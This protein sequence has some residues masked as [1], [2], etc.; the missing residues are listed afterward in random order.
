[1]KRRGW[2]LAP[3]V[4]AVAGGGVLLLRELRRGPRPDPG[5]L[6][7]SPARR[8]PALACAFQ[9]GD[10]L[11][12]R[13]R[14][15]S[16]VEIGKSRVKAGFEGTMIWEVR[17]RA[18]G[19]GNEVVALLEGELQHPDRTGTATVPIVFDLDS[20]CRLGAIRPGALDERGLR[21]ARGVLT[22]ME[23]VFPRQPLAGWSASQR[24]ERGHV[25]VDYVREGDVVRRRRMR[26]AP[27]G[28][29]ATTIT[30]S[31]STGHW[32]GNRL[33]WQRLEVHEGSRSETSLLAPGQRASLVVLE[34]SALELEAVAPDPARFAALAG[35]LHL[36]PPA[37]PRADSALRFAHDP[38]PASLASRPLASVLEDFTVTLGKGASHFSEAQRTVVQYLRLRPE[39]IDELTAM[40]RRRE[41][42][43]RTAAMAFL[44]LQQTGGARAHG[45]LAGLLADRGA[46]TLE[47][48]HAARHLAMVTDPGP[49]AAQALSAAVHDADEEVAST[50]RLARGTLAGNPA[51]AP[52]LRGKL[53]VELDADLARSEGR[54]EHA[55][56]ILALGAARD[57]KRAPL[58]RPLLSS[59][60]DLV[61]IEALDALVLMG[62][63]PTATESADLAA[64][65]AGLVRQQIRL[66]ATQGQLARP[67]AAE[68]PDLAARLA[69]APEDPVL[70]EI[71]I[72]LLGTAASR[73]PAA[74]QALSRHFRVERE[75][76]LLRAIGEYVD[77]LSL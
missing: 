12:W 76:A 53:L 58:V 72:R 33:G 49:L 30:R 8:A 63:P 57:P 7:P 68:V 56:A 19:T 25:Q 24:D 17:A 64:L 9:P 54:P 20:T 1:M 62:A 75:P 74:R 70:R 42:P 32:A 55:A 41:L 71:Y 69:S 28:R 14:T 37:A 10:R 31:E 40:L 18:A 3:A 77:A 22:E 60:H 29:L 59:P 52:A 21:L 66:Q 16:E 11:A 44:V 61:C 23:F 35:R 47:R 36:G 43:A 15:R 6:A 34:Q 2:I 26:Y 65:R 50:A 51:L 48:E 45:A 5:A 4:L 13:V 73:T 27:E 38:V 46:G 39:A 67:T